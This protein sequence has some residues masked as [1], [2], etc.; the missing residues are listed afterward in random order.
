MNPS[1]NAIESDPDKWIPAD[2]K[3]FPVFEI[4]REWKCTV[5]HVWNLIK[6]GEIRVPQENID[7]A[8]SRA[9]IQVPRDAYVDFLRQRSRPRSESE[10]AG[11][12]KKSARTG[13]GRK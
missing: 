4:A 11:R 6:E 3:S 5:Q 1:T 9:E 12:A 7:R 10:Q 8:T 2:R 13:N